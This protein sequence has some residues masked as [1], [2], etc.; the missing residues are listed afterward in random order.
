MPTNLSPGG[1]GA[2]HD[3]GSAAVPRLAPDGVCLGGGG[4]EGRHTQGLRHA[5]GLARTARN[6][7]AQRALV[8]RQVLH[9]GFGQRRAL[10]RQGAANLRCR[11]RD[12]GYTAVREQRG[13]LR[14]KQQTGARS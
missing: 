10:R 13:R 9:A 7:E 4:F 14:L 2:H 1:V 5:L 12:L 8:G 11:E 3:D 6:D